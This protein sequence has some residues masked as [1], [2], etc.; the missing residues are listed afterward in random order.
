M[1]VFISCHFLLLLIS[2]FKMNLSE[3]ITHAANEKDRLKRRDQIESVVSF[4]RFRLG[5]NAQQCQEAA[6]KS[7]IDG[8]MW[9]ELLYEVDS[10]S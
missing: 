5:W 4:M 9:E 10:N 1:D 8:E 3:A 2:N 7:G 6:Q